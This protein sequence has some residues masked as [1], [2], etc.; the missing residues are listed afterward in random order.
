MRTIVSKNGGQYKKWEVIS[1][2]NVLEM[3]VDL[4]TD[5]LPMKRIMALLGPA[6]LRLVTSISLIP[7]H[8]VESG[9]FAFFCIQSSLP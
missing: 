7:S 6:E 8:L 4:P 5:L 1:I 9:F 2:W 3:T